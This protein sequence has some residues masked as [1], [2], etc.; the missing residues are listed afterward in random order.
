MAFLKAYVLAFLLGYILTTASLQ[1]AV[2]YGK[3]E[4]PKTEAEAEA[5]DDGFIRFPVN[6]AGY[7]KAEISDVGEATRVRKQIRS[8]VGPLSLVTDFVAIGY[9]LLNGNPDGDFSR[10]GLDPGL[11]L[12]RRIF[13]L[14]YN[15][16]KTIYYKG[17][18]ASIPDQVDF[19]HSPSC[20]SGQRVNVYSGTASY[21][22]K[23]SKNLNVGGDARAIF[24]SVL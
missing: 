15:R 20:A 14:T 3:E 2:A 22:K 16:S 10:G 13:K 6:E 11:R 12:T 4:T 18:S 1:C 7:E 5:I 17:Q 9:N 8:P 21:Q 24:N 23:L 19:Q